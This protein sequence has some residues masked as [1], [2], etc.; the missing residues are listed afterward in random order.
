MYM[1]EQDEYEELL[2]YAVVAPK[3]EMFTSAPLKLPSTSDLS[4]ERLN[5]QRK[6]DIS[7]PSAGILFSSWIQNSVIVIFSHILL[8]SVKNAQF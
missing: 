6:E 1:N 4:T 5:S 2:H 8:T 3:L 7:Q